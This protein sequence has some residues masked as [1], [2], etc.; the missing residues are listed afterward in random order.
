MA[1]SSQTGSGTASRQATGFTVAICAY[2]AVGRIGRALDAL[3]RIRYAGPWEILVVDN[4]STDGTAEYV[5]SWRAFFPSM[6]VVRESVPGVAHARVR[7]IAESR[8]EWMVWVDDDNLLPPDYLTMGDSIVRARKDIGIVAGDS[9]LLELALPPAWFDQV[10]SCYAVG[11]Q[12]SREGQHGGGAFCWGAGTL[13]RRAAAQRIL[14]LGFKPILSG[15]V[16]K[17]QLAGEDAEICLA[18]RMAGWSL[19][20]SRQLLIEHAIEPHRMTVEM[21]RK[22][23]FGFGLSSIAIEVY[24]SHFAPPLKRW[25]YRHDLPFAVYALAKFV[26]R[27]FRK[28]IRRDMRACAEFWASQGTLA[29][30]FSG[31]RPSRVL[32]APFFKLT[33]VQPES[34]RGHEG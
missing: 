30:L 3:V 29:G 11:R 28:T 10:S 32:A 31:M 8:H 9:R 4:A 2:N 16:G 33:Q 15:R 13:L 12:F 34:P 14:D 17:H 26:G 22:T 7:A 19:I 25:V 23:T 27:F 21:L 20:Y 18:I 5:A 6:R 1:M 24:R